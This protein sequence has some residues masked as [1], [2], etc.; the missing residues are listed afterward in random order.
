[1]SDIL[2]TIDN[3][4]DISFI[5]GLTLE[6]I[7]GQMLSDFVAKYQEI[8]GK[9]IQLSKSDPNR[10]IMLGCAQLIYQGMQNIDKGGK[11]N[12]LKYA[13]DGYLENMG[14]LKK[15]TR[16]PA[17][18][19]Q[20]PVRFTLSGKRETAT[21]IPQGTR[22]T[23]A[24]EVY[25]ATIEYAEI[26]PGETEVTVMAEC[27]EAGTIGNDFAAGELTTLVDPI[28]FIS[29]VENT[30]KSTGGTEVES[31]QNMAER[32]Y[33]APSSYSTAG[34]DDA[35][36][37]WVK[38]SNP[39]IGDVKITSPTPGL[40]DIR[41]VMA[42]GTVPDDT[43]IAAVTAAV[44]QRGKR[45]LTDQVQVRRPE[46]EE[47]GID[48]T[49]YINTSDSNAA[50]AIQAQAETAIED[51]KLWQACKVGRDI[52]PD[53]LIARLNNAGAKRA[54]VRSP[55]FRIIGET[56]KAQCTGANIVYG[57]LEDD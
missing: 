5:D 51:Y 9:K 4:P 30:Q 39:F 53:E 55:A 6:D 40:V 52:N 12:F 48:V 22:V 19:A 32:I 23:A 17:K 20:A 36:E 26:P 38:D 27:T 46:I 1:M 43:T 37:Y 14:A 24:Y 16:N 13:Y 35:Y 7:Q 54:E 28:G 56:A 11:M 31:D 3:L 18:P 49:Y 42:D 10:I 50:T 47:Y 33:L 41:F 57:G 45:P 29:K 15:V 8:T 2:N 44:N 34:P 21:S 25:F